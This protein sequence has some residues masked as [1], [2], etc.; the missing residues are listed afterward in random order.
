MQPVYDINVLQQD[1]HTRWLKPSEVLFILQNYERFPLSQEPAQRPPSGSLF[2]FNR[3]ILRFF[4]KDGH[5]W[6][7]KRDGRTVGE[8]HERLKVG[9]V[10]VLNCYYA[11]GEQNPYFQRRSYWMLDPAYDHIVLVHYREVAEGRYVSGSISNLS[12]ESCS[13][14]NQST[15]VSNAQF[16]GFMSGTN[17]LYEPYR[18]SCSPGS[19]EEVSSKFVIENL[20]SDRIN[21]MDKSLSDGQ[22]SRPEV[23]Q[24]LRKLAVQLSLDDD[25]NSIF[26]DDLPVYTDRNENLQ[27]QDFGT[28]DSLQESRENLLHGLE[29]TGQGQLEEA[30]KQKNYNSIQSLKTF[31]DHVMQQNQSPCLDYG[32]ERK[33]SPS[34]K[35]MLELSSSSAG[36]DSHVNTSNISVVDGI[37]ESSNCSTRAFG[38]ASPARNMF[39]HDAWISS[40]ERVD[41]SATPFE[42]SENLTWLT[43]ESR[44]TGNLIS[45]SDL[46]LQLSAT[47]RF[48]LGSGNPVESPTSSSQLSDAGVHH[49]S[50]TSIVEAN[51]L[52]RKENSTD[53]M[54]TVPLA[55]GNDTYTPDFS[56]SWFDHSQFESSVGM[57]SSLTV[58]QKQRFSIHEICPEWA[59]SFES[60]KVIITG[61]FLCNPSEC[62]WAVMFGD[63]EVPL[64]IVQDGVLRCQAPQHR[65]GKVTLCITSG[66]RESCSEVREFEF[67]AIAKTSSSIGTSSSIDATKSAEELSLLAR[68]VQIL[69]CGH[70][71]LTV[72]KGAVAEVEQSR[73]LKTT[74]DPWRQI[75]E[76][77]QV[78][79]ESSLGSIE[80]IMQELLKDKLQHWISSKNQ[81]NDGASCLLSKQE[82]G[83]IH[84]ISGLGYEWALNPILSAGVG[85]NFRDAN[86]WTALHWAAHFGREN[87]VAELLA[88]GAS[89]GAVTDPTPQDP[90]GKTPGFIASARGHKGLAGYLSEVA[91]TSHL[92]SLTMEE[93]QIS[94]VSA[95]VEAERAVESI[96]QRSVQ[97]HGGGTEDELSLKD[98]L[99]A[100]RNAAQAAARIQAAFRAH[101]FRKRRYKAALSQDDYGM[102]QEDIQGLSAASRLFHGSHDQKFDKAALSIQKK[103]RGWKGRKDFLT[104]RHHVVKIQ[105]H[106]RGHQ[107]RRKYRDILRA[108]SVVEKVVLRW[109]RRGVGL[110]GF[111]AEPELLGDEEEE[112]DVAK[113]F[114]KQKVDAALDEAMSRVLSMVDSPDARQQYRRM[115]ERYRQAMPVSDEATSRFRDDFEIIENDGFMN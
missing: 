48:L 23:S 12:T 36:V 99:A 55:A 8:A 24:A 31:D 7:R 70:D 58:A 110:R 73:K 77:L 13:T 71:S 54:G 101:S 113:V 42:E 21:K 39:N 82:Q 104:L 34:W 18:S 41:M 74:D 29:F 1:A 17:G 91:L 35:D 88:A 3:R 6:R 61:E 112:E 40:S 16:R 94:K 26:F 45:E 27:D 97:I 59:F 85:I 114:R 83:I 44:P 100:V 20:E 90:V 105:A 38:S 64:E 102:T 68:L 47:R 79:C 46:S 62:A 111:R 78:G 50:G 103:Y 10:D 96:S 108:V 14:F 11:H 15:S 92:S 37:S 60:T 22:S 52:L 80:W 69:L 115:L 106:V 51:F 65:P 107:V 86:G 56:G 81:G 9:N 95:E 32:I 4:R 33:Q 109:R 67:R 25:D 19:V 43:A 2:L 89:A 76:S 28:R 66:N 57:Y 53:W 98:S 72:S 5:M 84:L 30:R 87:M 49:S 93:N 75:I 63:L